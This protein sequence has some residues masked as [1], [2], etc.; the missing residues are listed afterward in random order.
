M[1]CEVGGSSRWVYLRAVLH[2]LRRFRPAG[3]RLS[4][5][6]GSH[7]GSV[8][9]V[10]TANTPTYGGGLRIAPPANPADGMLDVVVVA[11][12]TRLAIARTLPR[13]GSG[14]HRNHPQV[15]LLRTR[16]LTIESDRPLPICAD[17]DPSGETPA[18]LEIAAGALLVVAPPG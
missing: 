2:A 13:L 4:G 1:R 11:A 16:R 8:T 6:F 14:G 18:T 10:A 7:E 17:G 12:M 15:T 5:D 3:V 9:L